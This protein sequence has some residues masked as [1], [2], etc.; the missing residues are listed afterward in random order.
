MQTSELVGW[1]STLISLFVSV[2]FGISVGGSS[3]EG[4]FLCLACCC[5]SSVLSCVFEVQVREFQYQIRWKIDG[6]A[7]VPQTQEDL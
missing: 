4:L 1:T 3:G 7:P 6:L 5:L 2:I